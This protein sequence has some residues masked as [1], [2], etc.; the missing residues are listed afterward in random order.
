MSFHLYTLPNIQIKG[1]VG[2]YLLH[3]LLVSFA[4]ESFQSLLLH[5]RR[6]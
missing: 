2:K 1:I 6:D 4:H 3:V 5:E